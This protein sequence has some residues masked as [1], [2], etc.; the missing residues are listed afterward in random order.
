MGSAARFRKGWFASPSEVQAHA[1][2]RIKVSKPSKHNVHVYILYLLQFADG[3]VVFTPDQL[4]EIKTMVQEA[5]NPHGRRLGKNDAAFDTSFDTYRLETN[6]INDCIN[7]ED[8]RLVE[9]DIG[10]Y[11]HRF[12]ADFRLELSH[13]DIEGQIRKFR[14]KLQEYSNSIVNKCKD[15]INSLPSLL[16]EGNIKGFYEYQLIIVENSSHIHKALQIPFSFQ[17]TS[18]CFDIVKPTYFIDTR[19]LVRISIPCTTVYGQIRA[20]KDKTLIRDLINA[21]YQ[22]ALYSRQ[23]RVSE[24]DVKRVHLERAIDPYKLDEQ[25]LQSLWSYMIDTMGGKTSNL[26]S[27]KLIRV[28]LT[29]SIIVCALT[30]G[31]FVKELYHFVKNEWPAKEAVGITTNTVSVAHEKISAPTHSE[32]KKSF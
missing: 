28:T 3:S 13:A 11:H 30:L 16:P 25:D 2:R 24:M 6:V 15:K 18:L 31:L 4:A 19:M 7:S 20:D 29:M 32:G 21:I 10:Y 1:W 9:A 27:F 8:T 12:I 22:H 23:T 5:I 14:G 17:T 26:Y